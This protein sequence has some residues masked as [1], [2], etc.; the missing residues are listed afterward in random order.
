MK[1]I[2]DPFFVLIS[3]I[4]I[5]VEVVYIIKTHLGAKARSI[6]NLTIKSILFFTLLLMIFSN[7][8]ILKNSYG[9]NAFEFDS[10]VA[11]TSFNIIQYIS[12][13]IFRISIILSLSLMLNS[14]YGM[15]IIDDN[16]IPL[17]KLSIFSYCIARILP[18][19]YHLVSINDN[20]EF[21]SFI[22]ETFLAAECVAM[23]FVI[24]IVLDYFSKLR[25]EIK[26]VQT[27]DKVFFNSEI[28]F[29]KRFLVVICISSIME[30]ISRVITALV[31]IESQSKKLN[32]LK[33]VSNLFR[34]ISLIL[35][36]FSI[37]NILFNDNFKIE[38]KEK[39]I[40]ETNQN[41]KFFIFETESEEENI[42]LIP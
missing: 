2:I 33:D 24:F 7:Y 30:V 40:I 26:T 4:I 38:N 15:I 32:F 6:R 17:F 39:F 29:Y 35:N 42:R 41:N 21:T 3:L 25:K 36:L 37:N 34:L 11:S 19:I 14:F 22:M 8:R 13:N 16:N 28:W 27:P 31:I 1:V 20:T 5:I 18:I 23:I 10:G 12:D 9:Q